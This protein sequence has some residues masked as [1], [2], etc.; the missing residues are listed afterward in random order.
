[1][2]DYASVILPLFWFTIKAPSRYR[3]QLQVP[4]S[5]K[6]IWA[7]GSYDLPLCN[8]KHEPVSYTLVMVHNESITK[9]HSL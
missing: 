5:D 2:D 1:M 9:Y 6:E 4:Q 3:L 8:T 7:P